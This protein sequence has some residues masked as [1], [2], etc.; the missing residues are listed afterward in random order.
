[1]KEQGKV[2]RKTGIKSKAILFICS[3]AIVFI[4]LSL[5][6]GYFWGYNLIRNTVE[7]GN[8]KMAKLLSATIAEMFD[9]EIGVLKAYSTSFIW[10]DA[11]EKSNLKYASMDKKAIQWYFADMDKK[12][13]EAPSDS[14]FI[15]DYLES[16]ASRRTRAYLDNEKDIKELFITDKFGGLVAASGKTSGFYQADEEWWQQA[17]DDGKGRVYIGNVEYNKSSKILSV[18]LAIPVRD[19]REGRVIGVCKAML[20]IRSFFEL[21]EKFRVGESGHAVLVNKE[22]YILYHHGIAPISM[23]FLGSDDYQKLLR[24][25]KKYIIANRPHIHGKKMFL[26]FAE[27]ESP[28][29][30]KAEINWGVFIDQDAK[31][32]FA[33]LRTF[34]FQTLALLGI[35]IAVLIPI[36]SVFGGILVKPIEKLHEAAE[37]IGKGDLDYKIELKTGDELEELANSFRMMSLNI[38]EK[39]NQLISQKAYSQNIIASIADALI[40]INSDATLRSVNKAALD[41]LGYKGD[42]LIGQPVKK[43][44][45]QEEG[46]GGDILYKYFQKIIDAGVAYNIGLTFLTKQ[47]KNIPVNFS[48]ALMYQNGKIIGIVGVAR[49]M[50]QIMAIISDL[51]TAK[52]NLENANKELQKLDRLKTDFVS[53]VSHELRTPLSITKEGISLVL[54]KIPGGLNEEQEKILGTS[55]NNIDRLARIIDAL[56][57]ISKIEA[58]KVGLKRELVDIAGLIRQ[59]ASSFNLSLKEKNLELKVN[60]PEKQ[61]DA[62]VDPDKITQVITNLMGNALKFTDWGYVEISL[63]EKEKQIECFVADT[64]LGIAEKNLPKVFSKFEQFGRLPGSGEKGTGLGL[65]ISKGIIELHGGKIWGESPAWPSLPAGRQGAKFSFNLPKYTTE[66]IFKE[67]LNNGMREAMDKKACMTLIIISILEFNKLKQ[68]FSDEKMDAI[69]RSMD[70]IIK[71]TL[72]RKS[73]VVLK[74]S[75]EMAIILADCDKEDVLS[76]EKRL[77]E[78]LDKDLTNKQLSQEIKLRFGFAVYPDEAKNDTELIEKAKKA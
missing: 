55:K 27:I 41:L 71:D 7:E 78:A 20:D 15:K 34:M 30:Q 52:N 44:F 1:M 56:L 35:L 45:L 38:K 33:P 43:I 47:G 23:N 29:L 64:G 57:D 66:E 28:L 60:I 39:E 77:K 65:A 75:G 13:V 68:K 14:L 49:D 12:W 19:E 76:V 73:N 48:G 53:M 24:S 11:I 8:V 3:A 32:V 2:K 25:K 70:G 31:E 5:S 6:L 36:G 62:F 16:R 4:T 58:G 18:S 69:L 10:V 26:A 67:Y 21:L 63:Q 50:R 59:I 42:E 51:D 17:F 54:D 46:A 9:K 74:V 72:R 40:V 37:K 22:N 61:I